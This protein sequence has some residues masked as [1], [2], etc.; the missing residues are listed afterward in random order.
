MTI[1]HQRDTVAGLVARIDRLRAEAAALESLEAAERDAIPPGGGWSVGQ[2]VEHLAISNEDYLPL[3]RELVERGRALPPASPTTTW[4]PRLLAG[5]LWRSL[6]KEGN[7][8]RAPTQI[9]PAASAPADA[10]PRYRASLEELDALLPAT[11]DLPWNRL[12]GH[13]PISRWVRPNLGDALMTVVVHCER[14]HRQIARVRAA[15][16][17]LKSN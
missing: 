17:A 3:L 15:T 1:L 12:V 6:E 9:R 5:L 10:L 13:S 14:H 11:G 7:R 2:V 4:K 8:F 16:G